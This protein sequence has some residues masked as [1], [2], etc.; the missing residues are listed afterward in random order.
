MIKLLV[1]RHANTFDKGD[2]LLRV[3]KRTDLPLSNSGKRQAFL[4][5]KYLAQQYP[6]IDKIYTST[7]QR[8]QQTA[9]IIMET[10]HLFTDVAINKI[11]DEIDYG[12]YDGIP[13]KEVIAKI[14]K[15]AMAK[16]ENQA[17]APVKWQI[18]INKIKKNWQDFA[19][20]II[21]TNINKNINKIILIITSNG[22]ARFLPCIL[23]NPV[24]FIA[25]NKIKLATGAISCFSFVNKWQV[26]Y[27]NLLPPK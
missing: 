2:V 14:G 27:W 23:D 13:E 7:L 3:G 8:T 18:D 20:N 4:L 1:A 26:D 9:K 12:D 6:Q 11:F 19:S 21:L 24:E 17:I 16:W 22:I 5:G 10:M 25:T 15:E